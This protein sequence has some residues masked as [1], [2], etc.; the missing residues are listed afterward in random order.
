MLRGAGFGAQG[1]RDH[2]HRGQ[3]HVHAERRECNQNPQKE[4]QCN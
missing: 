1:A 2:R 4:R 3:E